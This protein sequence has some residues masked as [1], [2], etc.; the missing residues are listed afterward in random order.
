MS[1]DSRKLRATQTQMLIFHYPM[2][3]VVEVT[4]QGCLCWPI[5][6]NMVRIVELKNEYFAREF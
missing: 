6:G 1:R 2:A 5:M 3:E 4:R